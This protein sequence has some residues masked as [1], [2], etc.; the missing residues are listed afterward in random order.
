M[1]L[2][3]GFLS[4]PPARG[5]ALDN[6]WVGTRAIAMGSA[7][8]GLADD[9]YAIYYNA[10]GL[11][12]LRPG[13]THAEADGYLSFTGFTYENAGA[14]FESHEKPIVPGLFA[15]HRF[16]RL[17]LG[18][19]Y[20]IP[21]GGGGTAYPDFMGTGVGLESAAGFQAF[22]LSAAYQVTD[23]IAIGGGAT[24]FAGLFD[25]RAPLGIERPVPAVA[26]DSSE[27]RAARATAGTPA[28]SSARATPGAWVS[29]PRAPR[30][31]TAEGHLVP[32]A[33]DVDLTVPSLGAGYRVGSSLEL[34]LATFLVIGR[35]ATQGQEAFDQGHVML[36]VGV[37]WAP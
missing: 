6:S 8:T 20:Y 35:R 34:D 17:A 18:F 2:V 7:L 15:A 33:N 30:G 3:A 10:A 16:D 14:V 31:A 36:V 27:T 1:S 12:F 9:P 25:T 21:Y 23:R 11:A 5:G 22:T 4:P 37:R 19:G 26:D 29:A 32:T 28:C 24:L 13:R